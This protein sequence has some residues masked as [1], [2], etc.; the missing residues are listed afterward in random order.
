MRSRRA[1]R[2]VR[3]MVPPRAASKH[4]SQAGVAPETSSPS[5]L[6]AGRGCLELHDGPHTRLT[7]ARIPAALVGLGLLSLSPAYAQDSVSG[8]LPAEATHSATRNTDVS[9][10]LMGNSPAVGLSADTFVV[11]SSQT[12]RTGTN[13]TSDDNGSPVTITVDPF[14]AFH[15]GERVQ[16]TVTNSIS[17]NLGAVAPYVWQFRIGAESGTGNFIQSNNSLGDSS[18]QGV[19]LGDLDGDGDLDAFVAN[20]N[21]P[22]RVWLN[23]GSGTFR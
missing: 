9:A 1:R 10:T 4:C 7:L 23:S 13:A 18:S 3:G 15:P 11:H 21:Q 8:V 19:G 20:Y 2:P 22:N 6:T 12:A 14:D 5:L 16:A 17:T